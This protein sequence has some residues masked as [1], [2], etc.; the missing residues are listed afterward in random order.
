MLLPVSVVIPAYNAERFIAQTLDSVLAQTF[1]AFEV[2]VVNDGSTDETQSIVEHYLLTDDRVRLINQ[3]NQGI[4]ATRQRG[5][6]AAKGD[7]IAFLDADDLWL[8]HNLEVHLRHFAGH[9]KL[10]ISFG[11]VE[12]MHLDGTPTGVLSTSR[13]QGIEP[14]HLFY[15]NLLT[16]TSNAIVRREV[17]DQIGG[18]DVDL[19]GTEDQEFFLRTCC[20]G[21]NVEGVEDVLVRYRITAGGLSS[22]LDLLE[23]DWLRFSDKVKAYAPAVVAQH[24]A[25][26]RAYF[27]RYIARRSLRVSDSR[28]IGLRFMRR[29]LKSDWTILLQEPRRTTLTLLAVCCKPL[30]PRSRPSG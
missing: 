11:R 6:A 19:C 18:F 7:F 16:T 14:E 25:K 4:S 24:G 2:I 21:W 17:F 8:P 10:G 5:K 12:F 27:L 20:F 26:S 15:E 28:T 3:S 29:A 1:T 23:D 9:P 22:R 30:L 13:L